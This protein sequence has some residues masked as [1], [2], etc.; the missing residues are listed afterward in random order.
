MRVYPFPSFD[1][2]PE[3]LGLDNVTVFEFAGVSPLGGAGFSADQVG[4]VVGGG[5]GTGDQ[6]RLDDRPERPRCLV[7]HRRLR[8]HSRRHQPTQHHSHPC[9]HLNKHT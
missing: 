7:H 2:W 3:P 4:G 8:W 6:L 9:Q 5:G 1:A